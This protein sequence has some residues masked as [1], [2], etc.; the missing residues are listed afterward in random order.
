[1]TKTNNSNDVHALRIN[2]LTQKPS[3][4]KFPDGFIWGAGT[5]AYQIEGAWNVDG[6]GESIWDR[7]SHTNGNVVNN[8]NGD[9]A[10]DH[11]NRYPEDIALAK[12][13]NLD[14]YRFSIS[15]PRVQPMGRGPFLESGYAFYDRLIDEVLKNGIEPF[16]TLYHWDLPQVL[17]DELGGWAHRDTG[18]RFADYCARMVAR[19]SDRVRFWATFNEP[20]CSAH[21]GHDVYSKHAPGLK[22]SALASQVAHNLLVAHGRAAQATRAT[23][24]QKIDLGI[25]L[26][27]SVSMPLNREDFRAAS[28]A[29]RLDFGTWLDPL[30]L[31]TYPHEVSSKLRDLQP[32]DLELI[33]QPLDWL[34]INYYFRNIITKS[35]Y[36]HPIPGSEYTDMPWEIHPEGLRLLLKRISETYNYPKLFVT[37]NGA[38]F[39]DVVNACGE[40]ND[41]KR[42]RYLRRHIEQIALAIKDGVDLQGYF[43]W[44][45]MDNFEWADGYQKR[46]GLI[47]V[48]YETQ[49]RTIKRSGEWYSKV[50]GSNSILTTDREL[51]RKHK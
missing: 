3:R 51:V 29:Q 47:H 17:Q 16:V 30:M 22:D 27:Q 39:N 35:Q 31:G 45:L 33:N 15:W 19:Y 38:A 36:S 18:K 42:I 11:Y 50:A 46:F 34:G 24:R 41:V 49:K 1:M 37:E 23:A 8:E 44:S 43:A 9:V 25:V 21:L 10:C 12:K 32:G 20:W 14:A 13:L 40:V 6:K 48:D 7:F 5:A 2:G 28:E 4:I 26:N